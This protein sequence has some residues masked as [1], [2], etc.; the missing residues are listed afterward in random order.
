MK[1]EAEY[2]LESKVLDG[3]VAGDMNAIEALAA[4]TIRETSY[5]MHIF[6]LEAKMM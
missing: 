5:E 6:S 3:I 2:L 4:V 1:R